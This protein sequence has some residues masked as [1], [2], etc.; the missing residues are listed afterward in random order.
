M[1]NKNH[2]ITHPSL[3]AYDTTLGIIYK[4]D[5]DSLCSCGIPYNQHDE[6]R[7]KNSEINLKHDANEK[8]TKENGWLS[9]T[10]K[11]WQSNK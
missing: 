9:S 10:K 4:L 5:L 2:C 1:K 7:D 3:K 11:T 6:W 8:L